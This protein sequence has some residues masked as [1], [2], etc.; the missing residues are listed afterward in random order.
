METLTHANLQP[1]NA[2]GFAF[3]SVTHITTDALFIP[4]VSYLPDVADTD[5]MRGKLGGYKQMAS[6]GAQILFIAF[7]FIFIQMYGTIT[8]G[9]IASV[10]AGLFLLI[11]MPFSLQYM[12]SRPARKKRE[13]RS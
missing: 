8:A 3:A 12:R 9:I 1:E 6:F 11:F 13:G 5:E 10:T 4:I 7:M 2:Q